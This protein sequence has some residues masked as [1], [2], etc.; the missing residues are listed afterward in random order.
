MNSNNNLNY[1]LNTWVN[2]GCDTVNTFTDSMSCANNT[3]Y[4]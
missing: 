1:A 3:P 2:A 4:V